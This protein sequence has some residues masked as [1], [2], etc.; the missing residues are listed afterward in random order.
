MKFWHF[1]ILILTF[2]H[3]DFEHLTFWHWIWNF[4]SRIL[5]FWHFEFDIGSVSVNRVPI[6]KKSNDFEKDS[7]FMNMISPIW[8]TNDPGTNDTESHCV[9]VQSLTFWH[10][11]PST[12]ALTVIVYQRFPQKIMNGGCQF[13]MNGIFFFQILNCCISGT[14]YTT[15]EQKW[16]TYHWKSLDLLC[17]ADHHGNMIGGWPGKSLFIFPFIRLMSLLILVY[18]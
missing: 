17:P 16:Y 18:L 2:W 15:V 7:L 13:F 6:T 10:W 1:G 4:D 9:P 8:Y 14:I 5:Q 12:V 3:W 11:P